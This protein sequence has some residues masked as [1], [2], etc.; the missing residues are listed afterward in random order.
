MASINPGMSRGRHRRRRRSANCR[1][2]FEVEHT[3]PRRTMEDDELYRTGGPPFGDP[4]QPPIPWPEARLQGMDGRFSW[5]E[6]QRG[7]RPRD[8]YRF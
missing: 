7:F 8:R 5:R 4:W 3:F 1:A 2:K 6:L